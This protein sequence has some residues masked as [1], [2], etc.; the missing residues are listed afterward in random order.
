MEMT[1]MRSFLFFAAAAALLAA[2]GATA[3]PPSSKTA[4]QPSGKDGLACFDNLAAPEFP[5]TA[6]QAHVDGSVWAYVHVSPQATPEKID[7]QVVSAWSKAPQLL[8]APVEKAVRSARIKP[9]CAGK[10]VT[11]VF[12]YQLH[13]EPAQT[14]KVTSRNEAPNLIWIESQPAIGPDSGKTHHSD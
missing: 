3:Q 12:R 4:Q 13:G 2:T 1:K 7:T 10:T 5:M 8:T 9:E 11:V 6:L 14:P